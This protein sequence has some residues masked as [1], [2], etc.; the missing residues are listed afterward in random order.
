M[1]GKRLAEQAHD[2]LVSPPGRAVAGPGGLSM[3]A[4]LACLVLVGLD[5][6]PAIVFVESMQTSGG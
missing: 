4:G 5:L 6:R 3:A 2:G 1:T